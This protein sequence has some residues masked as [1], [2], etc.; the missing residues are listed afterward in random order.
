MNCSI[1]ENSVFSKAEFKE[2]FR[3]YELVQLYTDVVPDEFYAPGIRAQFGNTTTRQGEDAAVNR[4]FQRAAFGTEQLP[5]YVLLEPLLNGKI[6][7][8]G[9]Y[10]E[11]KINNEAAF[12][13]FLKEPEGAV[14]AGG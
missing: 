12:A 1:N 11:G 8:V 4:W 6:R 13:R 2:L 7:V 3:S 9:I 5:L 14:E 10:D